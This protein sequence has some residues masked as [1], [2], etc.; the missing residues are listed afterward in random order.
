MKM[1]FLKMK[2]RVI[3]YRKCKA[4]NNDGFVSSLLSL[5][6]NKKVLDEKGFDAFTGIFTIVLDKRA[7]ERKR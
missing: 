4:F 1:N 7:P 6:G 3:I 5:L 2:R